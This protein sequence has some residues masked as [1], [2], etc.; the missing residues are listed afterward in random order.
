V[1]NEVT[2]AVARTGVEDGIAFEDGELALRDGRT[3]AWRW[4]GA[5]GGTPVLRLQGTPG[6]RLSRHPDP[7]I[8][9]G[10]RVCYLQAD[11]P[12]YGGSSRKL[13]RGVIDFAD[14]LVE[15]L[16][17]HGLDRVPVIGGSGGGPH[18]L[19]IA[20]RHPERISAV[21]VC[22]GASPLVP[23]EVSQMVGVNKQSY[24]ASEKGWDALF[25]LLTAVRQRL[26]GDEGTQGVLGDAPE[27]DRDVMSNP[28]WQKVT[29]ANTNEALRPGAEGWTD[30]S[31]ALHRDWDFDLGAVKASVTWWHGDDD[32]NAPLPAARR[33]ATLLRKVDFRLWHDEGHFAPVRYDREI[34]EE[35]LSR[36]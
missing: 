17:A 35:L 5:E 32:M 9:L 6:S 31:M 18:A 33:A 30:E 26:L 21:T 22:V 8:Q 1:G 12:G 13:G 19:A 15:L 4:W 29:R 28:I 7:S 2:L 10:L 11:R 20:A 16:D 34:I 27:R 25:E 23:D 14:D 36:S 24:A 3:L